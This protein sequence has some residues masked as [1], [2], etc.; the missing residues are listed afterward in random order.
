M[1]I[2]GVWYITRP[3]RLLRFVACDVSHT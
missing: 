1:K 2:A 3:K